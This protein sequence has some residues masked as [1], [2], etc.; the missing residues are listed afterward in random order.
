MFSIQSKFNSVSVKNEKRPN[1]YCLG[2]T[3][4]TNRN[5]MK[6]RHFLSFSHSTSDFNFLNQVKNH[7]RIKTI[8][9][10]WIEYL[11]LFRILNLKQKCQS[12]S[13]LHRAYLSCKLS[14]ALIP[15]DKNDRVIKTLITEKTNKRKPKSHKK[16]ER[17]KYL[18]ARND[19]ILIRMS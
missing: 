14:N 11:W 4:K 19:C 9:N 2:M 8:A 1:P 5:K 13:L 10:L 17:Y 16:C 6:F 18:R 3:S 12:L 7:T 15:S